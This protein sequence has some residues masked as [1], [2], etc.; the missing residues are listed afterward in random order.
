M[1]LKR[2]CGEEHNAGFEGTLRPRSEIRVEGSSLVILGGSSK[3]YA[4][5]PFHAIHSL[6]S[7]FA[8]FSDM[9]LL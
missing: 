7:R 6:D 5:T 3:L 4:A 1:C 2:L 9:F 8:K